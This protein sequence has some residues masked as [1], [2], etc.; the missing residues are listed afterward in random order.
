M[1]CG[2]CIFMIL[3]RKIRKKLFLFFDFS[4]IEICR[5][6][7]NYPSTLFLKRMVRRMQAAL[8]RAYKRLLVHHEVRLNG[9]CVMDNIQI[10]HA[11]EKREQIIDAICMLNEDDTDLEIDDIIAEGAQLPVVKHIKPSYRRC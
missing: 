9:N 5:Y 7:E 10:L 2:A 8:S 6:F 3:V 11:G 4:S 1:G